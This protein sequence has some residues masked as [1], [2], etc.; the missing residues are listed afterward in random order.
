MAWTILRGISMNSWARRP[1]RQTRY[2]GSRQSAD[3]NREIPDKTV[4]K[5]RVAPRI[6][7]VHGG[8]CGQ[9]W[10]YE[11]QLMKG[12][13]RDDGEGK[14]ERFRGRAREARNKG[15]LQPSGFSGTKFTRRRRQSRRKFTFPPSM[16]LVHLGDF[17]SRWQSTHFPART[18]ARYMFVPHP[19]HAGEH[20]SQRATRVGIR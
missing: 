15:C 14:G 3:I 6:N 13:P 12:A 16:A 20:R 11:L 7:N 18:R 9:T 1:M 19:V 2:F 5:I 17:S 4:E 10:G 8:C